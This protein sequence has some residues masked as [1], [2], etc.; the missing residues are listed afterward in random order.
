VLFLRG[1]TASLDGHRA[2]GERRHLQSEGEFGP[3][4]RPYDDVGHDLAFVA[5]VAALQDIGADRDLGNAESAGGVT[6]PAQ[7]SALDDDVGAD[8]RRLRL[9]VDDQTLDGT[10]LDAVLPRSRQYKHQPKNQSYPA[11]FFL[12]KSHENPRRPV[13]RTG[14]AGVNY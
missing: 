5:E 6:D 9:P 4:L 11:H 8:Q 7:G 12:R 14:L 1:K 3:A 10:K 13:I 2:T